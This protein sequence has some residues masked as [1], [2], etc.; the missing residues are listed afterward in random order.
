MAPYAGASTICPPPFHNRLRVYSPLGFSLLG[1]RRHPSSLQAFSSSLFRP[2]CAQPRANWVHRGWIIE[3]S[4]WWFWR[5]FMAAVFGQTWAAMTG[6]DDGAQAPSWGGNERSEGDGA[7]WP[8][9]RGAILFLRGP[10]TQKP[11]KRWLAGRSGRTRTLNRR[12]WRPLF[13]H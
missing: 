6:G 7:G 13:Y 3:N 5:Y 12:F 2:W 11:P 1:L 4:G 8:E 9:V 10:E